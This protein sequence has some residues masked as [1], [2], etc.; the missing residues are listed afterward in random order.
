MDKGKK[1]VMEMKK[2]EEEFSAIYQ[3]ARRHLESVKEETSS[4]TSDEITIDL[5]NKLNITSP[6]ET[7]KKEVKNVPHFTNDKIGLL[8]SK[9]KF[10]NLE[11]LETD[12]APVYPTNETWKN[13]SIHQS[14]EKTQTNRKSI[15]TNY[16]TND[17]HNQSET[18]LEYYSMNPANQDNESRMNAQALPFEPTASTSAHSIGQDLWRQLKR[19]QIPVFS[20][21]Q[22]HYQSWG[23]L[24]SHVSI[25][26]KL[27]ESTSYC[28]FDS[29]WLEKHSRS[30][31]VWD[32]QPRLMK[33]L[34][35]A[36]REN[37]A[38][39]DGK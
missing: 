33:R 24:S 27:Q 15:F 29:I 37:M 20:G 30:Q 36:W 31:K 13:V 18:P 39:S 14:K 34:K 19:V 11:L 3:T 10:P 21:D 9:C 35:T 2:L 4:E 7:Y 8:N 17:M 6:S 26:P 5:T 25:A 22:R 28:N 32:I 12:M 1:V 23:Q 38:E 16:N